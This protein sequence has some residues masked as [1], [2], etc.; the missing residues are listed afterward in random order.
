MGPESQSLVAWFCD[1]RS[2]ND[3][4]TPYHGTSSKTVKIK[5]QTLKV[6]F[7]SEAETDS[8]FERLSGAVIIFDVTRMDWDELKTNLATL[9]RNHHYEGLPPVL[10]LGNTGHI[11]REQPRRHEP[12]DLKKWA[13]VSNC[14]YCEVNLRTGLG[15]YSAV[16]DL[17]S[18]A[19]TWRH[20][21]ALDVLVKQPST[22]DLT[23]SSPPL[24][25]LSPV[26]PSS[27]KEKVLRMVVLGNGF[28]GK[29]AVVTRWCDGTFAARAAFGS[30]KE[31]REK[32]VRYGRQTVTLSMVECP[33]HVWRDPHQRSQRLHGIHGAIIVFDLSDKSTLDDVYQFLRA[34]EKERTSR[35][36]VVIGNK[37]DLES[38]RAIS[39]EELKEYWMWSNNP[40]YSYVEASS[41][42]G[43][44]VSAA[45]SRLARMIDASLDESLQVLLPPPA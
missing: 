22:R 6:A 21:H 41:K 2:W 16:T 32:R 11:S 3:A 43:R 12:S 38:E 45:F 33:V 8:P 4:R 36:V 1:H 5:T 15:V 40:K 19:A 35:P 13:T 27:G 34:L 20:R 23:A 7:G 17:C 28:V 24:A 42:T 10:I 37:A 9:I 14:S 18:A 29:T 30:E 31:V 26:A 39:A 25:P 44:G